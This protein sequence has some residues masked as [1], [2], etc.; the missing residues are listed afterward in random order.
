MKQAGNTNFTEEA[1][2]MA[3]MHWNRMRRL[4]T[5]CCFL[6]DSTVLRKHWSQHYSILAFASGHKTSLERELRACVRRS[7][8]GGVSHYVREIKRAKAPRF[9][10][11]MTRKQRLR[12]SRNPRGELSRT[13]NRR[14]Q[15]HRLVPTFNIKDRIDLCALDT[16]I[17]RRTKARQWQIDTWTNSVDAAVNWFR[18]MSLE[19]RLEA[20][21]Q[22]LAKPAPNLQSRTPEFG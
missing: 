10:Y 19:E 8:A 3:T 22:M 6:F 20:A 4:L 1:I 5:I 12:K 7:R 14:S 13:H 11:C 9:T 18:S 16:I 2:S 15:V 21:R 17:I